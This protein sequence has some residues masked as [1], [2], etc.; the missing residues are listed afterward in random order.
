M[1][2]FS[3]W[4]PSYFL[5]RTSSGSVEVLLILASFDSLVSLHLGCLAHTAFGDK[6]I[7]KGQVNSISFVTWSSYNAVRMST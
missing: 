5:G 6:T 4:I 1:A 7:K 2:T 3:T